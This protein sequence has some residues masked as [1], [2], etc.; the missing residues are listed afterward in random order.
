MLNRPNTLY[1]VE[2]INEFLITCTLLKDCQFIYNIMYIFFS[3]RPNS[4]VINMV[5][6]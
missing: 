3:N 5:R 1:H 2:N 4:K 6:M